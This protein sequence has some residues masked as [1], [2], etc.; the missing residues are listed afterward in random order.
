MKDTE[1]SNLTRACAR[2][3]LY[4]IGEEIDDLRARKDAMGLRIPIQD[5]YFERD[6]PWAVPLTAE[7]KEEAALMRTPMIP[8]DRTLYLWA[9]VEPIY[10]NRYLVGYR[11]AF[12]LGHAYGTD[13]FHART[14][15]PEVDFPHIET[16][17]GFFNEAEI[18][19]AVDEARR[20]CTSL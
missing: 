19:E 17:T 9:S 4:Q 8:A 2:G 18:R 3:L 13:L 10:R 6:R 5:D 7:E 12:G 11:L 14:P 20:R 16:R 1:K 15:V